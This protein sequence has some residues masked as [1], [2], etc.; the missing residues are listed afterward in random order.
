MKKI[1]IL[2]V[3]LI[4]VSFAAKAQSCE[5]KGAND[6]STVMVTD[7]YTEGEKI[8]VLLGN[9][10]DK[11]CANVTVVVT[12]NGKE[13]KGYGKSCPDSTCRIEISVGEPIKSYK[14]ESVSGTKC[15]SI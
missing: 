1:L 7:D 14:V 4:G 11:I 3:V 8:V 6:G 13:K 9:D 15:S 10:S 5:I 2:L 12:V